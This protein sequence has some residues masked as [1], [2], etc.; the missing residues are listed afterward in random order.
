MEY[1]Y[2]LLQILVD[3]PGFADVWELFLGVCGYIKAVDKTGV[4]QE[5]ISSSIIH[6]TSIDSLLISSLS[7]AEPAAIDV[8]LGDGDL[9]MGNTSATTFAGKLSGCCLNIGISELNDVQLYGL[10]S[11]ARGP[12]FS[13]H[14]HTCSHLINEASLIA[15][16]GN[17]Y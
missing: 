4:Y 6:S 11:I 13:R 16:V 14:W 7:G 17:I 1:C 8:D 5:S 12:I 15:F 2:S 9:D 10:K 3:C